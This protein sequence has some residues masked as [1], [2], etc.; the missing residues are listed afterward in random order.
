M[1]P[2]EKKT[3]L[4]YL[5]VRDAMRKQVTSL[6]G[7]F[8][9]ESGIRFLIKYKVGALLITDQDDLPVGV[10]SKT[11]MMGAYYAS[12]ALD[13][14]LEE[15]MVS[16]P[17]FCSPTDALESTLETMR[18]RGIYRIYVSKGSSERALGVVAYPDIV[19]LLYR[20]CRSCDQSLMNRRNEKLEGVDALRFRVRDVMTPSVTSFSEQNSLAEIMEGLSVNRFGAVLIRDDNSVPVGVISKTDLILAYK[21]G[22]SSDVKARTILS[23][24]SVRAC[25]ELEFIEDAISKMIFSE[26]HRFFVFRD[27]PENIIGVLSLRDAARLRSGSCH[28]CVSSRIKVGSGP[29]A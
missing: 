13:T 26:V 7:R 12:V 4:R 19:G 25:E 23:S 9:I 11:D 24:P 29:V 14:P 21:R 18:S 8:S 22:I 15:I 28:A 5:L 2:P 1:L 16:P 6:A 10:V 20:Y 27:Q 17:L 3:T